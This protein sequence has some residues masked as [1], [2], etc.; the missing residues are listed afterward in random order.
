MGD[1][2]YLM[3]EMFFTDSDTLRLVSPAR[4]WLPPVKSRTLRQRP[5]DLMFEEE[6]GRQMQ[7]RF[8]GRTGMKVSELAWV[9]CSSVDRRPTLRVLSAAYEAGIGTIDTA[10]IPPL[11]RKTGGVPRQS[12]ARFGATSPARPP[13]PRLRCA[14]G[15]VTGRTMKDYPAL[16]L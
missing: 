15:W 5:G 7:Y 6:Q 12:L 13:H 14:G 3:A 10:D 1:N 8:L 11:G 9:P 4:K 16:I 2:C